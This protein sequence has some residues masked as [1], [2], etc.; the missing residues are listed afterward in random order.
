MTSV[1]AAV[2]AGSLIAEAQ[3]R[4]AVW[5]DAVHPVWWPL[6]AVALARTDTESAIK[7]AEGLFPDSQHPIDEEVMAAANAAIDSW[8]KGYSGLTERQMAEAL[9]T[10]KRHHYI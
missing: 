6:I 5:D 1:E 8:K 3:E 10:A 7:F 9:K 4:A 2:I